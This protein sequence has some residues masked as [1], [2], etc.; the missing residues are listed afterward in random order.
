MLKRLLPDEA[1]A[2]DSAAYAKA[3]GGLPRGR[4]ETL[5]EAVAAQGWSNLSGEDQMKFSA[6]WSAAQPRLGSREIRDGRDAGVFPPRD[7]ERIF[8]QNLPQALMSKPFPEAFGW[9][10]PEQKQ[11][12]R[13]L[14]LTIWKRGV[15][16][17]EPPRLPRDWAQW[18]RRC[19]SR[20]CIIHPRPA[21]AFTPPP[22]RAHCLRR[23]STPPSGGC[24]RGSTCSRWGRTR[25][26]ATSGRS[27]RAARS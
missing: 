20:A 7:E 17:R 11:L 21:R 9:L 22:A 8:G 25:R 4:A 14:A 10:A 13:G 1:A 16:V 24:A 2:A 18:P 12:A 15:E 19:P 3:M 23:T 26:P 27:A 5:L 6:M